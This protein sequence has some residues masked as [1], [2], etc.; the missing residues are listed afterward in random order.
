[1][2]FMPMAE[3]FD[4]IHSLGLWIASEVARQAKL[5][6]EAGLKLEFYSL[7][8]AAP[9]LLHGS[10]ARETL[11]IWEEA[12]LAPSLLKVEITESIMAENLPVLSQNLR[13]LR[14]RGVSIA[15]DDFGTGYSSLSYLE[16][17]PVD[18]IKIDR[19]FVQNL[20]QGATRSSVVQAIG[21]LARQLDLQV[22]VEGVEDPQTIEAIRPMVDVY[23]WQGYH[24]ARPMAAADFQKYC[25]EFPKQAPPLRTA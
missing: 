10:F 9:Q 24:F 6:Q 25:T 8:A 5:M 11:R 20:Q 23:G 4:L 21:L 7:N 17:F 2:A 16:Q 18:C 12:G 14:E 13:Q 15:F 19:I 1:M 3:K 22:I